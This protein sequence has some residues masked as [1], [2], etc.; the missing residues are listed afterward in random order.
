[1]EFPDTNSIYTEYNWSH[2]A[3]YFIHSSM[4][5]IN[6]GRFVYSIHSRCVHRYIRCI[7]THTQT[8]WNKIKQGVLHWYYRL[9]VIVFFLGI[10]LASEFNNENILPIALST[11]HSGASLIGQLNTKTCNG[12]EYSDFR[13][14]MD[15][16]RD[17]N[18]CA[19]DACAVYSADPSQYIV[20]KNDTENVPKFVLRKGTTDV[21]SDACT[22]GGRGSIHYHNR[23]ISLHIGSIT[24]TMEILERKKHIWNR[25]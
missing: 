14:W 20:L 11:S 21:F 18:S 15:C 17:D 16:I 24:T 25:R 23:N 4:Y 8:T 9:A 12:T 5:Y 13:K 2:L 19:T 3:S 6:T 22:Y 7:G 10:I 1:M